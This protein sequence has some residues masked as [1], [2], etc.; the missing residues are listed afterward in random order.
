MAGFY[1]VGAWLII[2]VVDVFFPAWGFPETALRFLIIATILCFPIA[3]I[4][5][6]IFDITTSGIVKTEPADPREVFDNSLKRSDYIILVAL[7]ATGAAI[8]LG[9]PQ[10]IVGDLDD[11][12]SKAEKI[13]NP[14][15]VLPFV[16]L[17]ANPDTGY[18]TDCPR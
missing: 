9:S 8:I 14:V 10:R 17:D 4:F 2:Q 3:L 12:A 15:A 18:F 13:A 6:W 7:L 1:V 5:S 11:A 16:N